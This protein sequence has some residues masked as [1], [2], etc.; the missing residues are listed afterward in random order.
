[1]RKS[2]AERSQAVAAYDFHAG[3]DTYAYRY[4]GV[5]REGEAVYRFRVYAPSARRVTLCGD[6]T[7]GEAM[8]MERRSDGVWELTVYT[9]IPL[10]GVSYALRFDSE[11]HIPDPYAH[12]GFYGERWGSLICTE[13]THRWQDAAWMTRRGEYGRADRPQNFY[14]V[15]LGSF[16]T[17]GGRSNT[18]GDAYLN[19]RELGELLARYA[20]DMAYT[21]VKLMPLTEHR[22]DA[23][24]GYAASGYFA[25]TSRHG[26]PDDLRAMIDCLHNEALG[27][28]MDLPIGFGGEMGEVFDITYPETQSFFLSAVFYWLR[29]F[30]LDGICLVGIQHWAKAGGKIYEEGLRFLALLCAA[31]HA[32][33]PDVLMIAGE[34]IGEM[35]GKNGLGFD[36]LLHGRFAGDILRY[37]HAD[38]T[39]RV[40]L[41]DLLVQSLSDAWQEQYLLSFSH[42]EVCAGHSSMFGRMEGSYLQKFRGVRTALAFQMIHPGKKLL[43]MGCELG[44]SRTWDDTV[45]PD[46]FLGELETHAQLIRYTRALNHFYRD[47]PCL[48]HGEENRN[49]AVVLHVT[50]EKNNRCILAALRIGG[51]EQGL[52]AVFNFALEDTHCRCMV[53]DEV[54]EC[55]EI[56]N[57]DRRHFGGEGRISEGYLHMVENGVLPLSI[58]AMTAIFFRVFFRE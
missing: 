16:A 33:F 26:T 39:R 40:C 10:E 36:L 7:A 3:T 9:N 38:Q 51:A 54:A 41:Y 14:E 57:T 2:D 1:M 20:S 18:G 55:R 25:P 53:G 49:G 6:V 27:A 8:A 4:F 58:P 29:E 47:E 24:H 32:E 28:V 35:T 11:L 19:Y 17:R 34:N 37:L 46:W 48:W 12:R 15:H 30:H 5:H 45:P 56:F 31:V 13:S 43:F 42:E 23:S 22:N 44:Q 52:L 50:S 21:H